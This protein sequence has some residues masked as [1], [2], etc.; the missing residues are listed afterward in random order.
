M[1][2]PRNRVSGRCDQKPAGHAEMNDPLRIWRLRGRHFCF[3]RFTELDDNVFS[4]AMGGED[5]PPD[6]PRRLPDSRSLER[7]RKAA[8]P[9]AQNAIVAH[10]NVDAARDRFHLRQFGH[11]LIVE[12]R[13]W[14]SAPRRLIEELAGV[15][16]DRSLFGLK[17]LHRAPFFEVDDA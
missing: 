13:M 16:C 12:E 8:E 5:D 17:R 6:E 11:R 1:R 4:G 2:V 14:S 15:L 9:G 10:A 3:R 7:L